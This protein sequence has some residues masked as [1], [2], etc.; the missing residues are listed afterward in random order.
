MTRTVFYRVYCQRHDGKIV[1]G[2]GLLEWLDLHKH[3][4][5][6]YAAGMA[7]AGDDPDEIVDLWLERAQEADR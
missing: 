7:V 3:C 5:G 4:E 2:R 6:R 1:P